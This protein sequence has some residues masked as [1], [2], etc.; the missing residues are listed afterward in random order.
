M[1]RIPLIAGNWKMNTTPSEGERLVRDLKKRLADVEE[2]EVVVAPPFTHL[3]RV[4]DALKGS[5]ISLAAQNV[6]WEDAGAFTGEISP[7]MIKELG[8][9]YVIT[10]HSERRAYFGETDE[11]VSKKVRA[12]LRC[13][14]I[15]IV[16]VGETLE[17]REAG[18]TLEVVGRQ[19]GGGL[20]GLE[21]SGLI[22]EADERG[23]IVIAYEPVWAIGTGKTATAGQAQ[24]V[25]SFIRERLER[26][27]GDT[28]ASRTRILY[29]G[30][31]KPDNIDG[32][33]AQPDIDGA[34]VGGASLDAGSFERIVKF[35]RG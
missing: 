10:G 9:R 24:E 28:A 15:P 31:V 3:H 1:E 16:C 29:G 8:C 32:L 34:L 2:R 11:T 35:R 27:L 25:H 33:M 13:G 21:A 30:S 22:S 5:S 12:A 19:L 17:E 14:M 4:G 23:M 6:Y 20:R 7:A 18:D 26:I